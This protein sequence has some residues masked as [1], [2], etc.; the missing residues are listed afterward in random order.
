MGR[1]LM[2]VK[3]GKID[4]SAFRMRVGVDEDSFQELLGSVRRDGVLV[5][6][7]LHSV[8]DKFSVVAGHRRLAAAR[9]AGHE[10]IPGY[11]VERKSLS[12]WSGAFAENLFRKDLTPI[13]M[14]AAVCDCLKSG[15]Y[16][17]ETLARAL[18]R[19]VQWIRFYT[20]VAS[21]P[22]DLA[23]AVHLEKLS[24]SAAHHLAEITDSVHRAMLVQ[25]AC[26][27]G[28]TARVTAAWLQAWKAGQSMQ[29]PGAVLP[30]AAGSSVP[31]IE[32]Y[33]PCV[34]CNRQQKMIDLH[35]TPVCDNCSG[36]LVDLARELA[37]RGDLGGH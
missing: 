29:D 22:D 18:G 23:L 8:G 14:A 24:V 36:L 35:Y 6:I 17:E 32:P 4:D 26:E 5:P 12:G 25:Y 13:E 3:V 34:I 37:S 19:S 27:N 21:W 10:E 20:E 28:A 30:A 1:K 33:T 31:A 11:V 16:D 7:L 2:M 15:D 9:L